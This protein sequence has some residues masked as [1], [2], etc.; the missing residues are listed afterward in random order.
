MRV[1]IIG[2]GPCGLTAAWELAKNGAN[3]TVV[4]KDSSL[5]G[6]CKTVR[7]DGYQFDLGGHR[8]ISRDHELVEDIKELMGPRLLARSRRSCILFPDRRFEYPLNMMDVLKNGAIGTNLRF[9]LGYV[10]TISGLS[11]SL[12]PV[13]SFQQWVEAKYGK[14]L[15]HEFF[16]PYTR[17]LWGVDPATLSGEWAASRIPAPRFIDTL[18]KSIGLSGTTKT[19]AASYLYPMG[20]MGEM[21]ET[22]GARIETLGGKVITGADAGSLVMRDGRAVA[23]RVTDSGGGAMDI[24]GDTFLSTA[25]LN[26]LADMID[27]TANPGT[28]LGHRSLRFLNIMLDGIEDLSPYTW[29]YTPSPQVIMTRVQEPKRRSPHSAPEGRTSVMLEIPCRKD[30]DVWNMP[31]GQL[32]DRALEGM[33]RLGYRLGPHVSGVF[34]TYAE[35]AYPLLTI[36]AAALRHAALL[37]AR[38]YPNVTSL[39]RQGLFRY[40]FMDEAM[41]MGRQWARNL[42]N[43]N[44]PNPAHEEDYG[45]GSLLRESGSIAV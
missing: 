21:F 22:M 43:P 12:S 41:L 17:K 11:R 6:L 31:D 10:A 29:Q 40:I 7:R 8:F 39:G 37:S 1:V 19:H 30:D 38:Q 33:S 4:E 26:R 44:G 28:G 36:Q 24:E 3:V 20:G 34:S 35:H 18:R 5:G 32:Q 9:A 25:P 16:G 27:P 23:I 42:M 14:P 2:G 45:A 13:G 15:Y